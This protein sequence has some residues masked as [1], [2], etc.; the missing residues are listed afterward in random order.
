M[1]K[2]LG[3]PSRILTYTS[4]IFHQADM[5]QKQLSWPQ[6]CLAAAPQRNT[7]NSHGTFTSCFTQI[8]Y[9]KPPQGAHAVQQ[10][11]EVS[12]ILICS[13][14]PRMF[15]HFWAGYSTAYLCAL[16]RAH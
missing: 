3:T 5:A 13:V 6:G 10:Q 16:G 7:G 14:I 15:F 2:T 1:L 8:R 9:D 4:R 12:F 11:S